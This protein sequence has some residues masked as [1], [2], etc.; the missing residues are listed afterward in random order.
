MTMLALALAGLLAVT[1]LGIDVF[2]IY[3]NKNRLQSAVDSAALA[4]VTYFGNVTFTGADPNCGAYSGMQQSAACTFALQNGMVA[5]E[6]QNIQVDS[7]AFTVTVSAQRIVPALFAKVVGI[8]Q[9]TVNATA[10]AAL[11][12]LNSAQH[13]LPI[14]LDSQTPYVYGQQI[15]MHLSGCGPGC[16]QGL[17]LQS[18]SF[19][20]TG[21]N[22]FQQNLANGGCNCTLTI[23]SI[24]SAEPGA[25]SGPVTQGVASLVASGQAQDPSGTWNSH[26]LGDP[27]SA[28]VALVNWAG[29]NGNCSAPV[30][31]FAEVWV[32]SANGTD[33]SAIFIQQVEPG[34][35]SGNPCSNGACHA[36]L[37]G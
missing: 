16:W 29:C 23:G 3:W 15:T 8:N 27:R 9:F 32:V 31:G 11:Q 33:I 34:T 6:I 28:M 4:G 22:A 19:G 35:G 7:T 17:G 5:A 37:T 21:G 2:H 25:K 14:G 36:T 20:S 13:V 10:T 18:Q 12:A 30:M 24:V 1:A 26:T